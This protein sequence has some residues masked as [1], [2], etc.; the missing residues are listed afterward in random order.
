MKTIFHSLF[1]LIILAIITSA[2]GYNLST[3]HTILIQSTDKNISS[4]LLARSEEIISARLKDFSTGIFNISIV[5]EK[6]QI[7]ITFP[8][9]WDYQTI[10][11]LIVHKG[12]I[13]FYETC[14]HQNLVELLNGDKYL[15]TL[16]TKSETDNEGAKIGCTTDKGKVNDFLGTLELSRQAKFTWSEEYDDSTFCLYALKL[17][18]NKGPIIT[19][20][21][22][23]SAKF[24]QERIQI[25]L[26]TDAVKLWSDATK[27]NLGKAIALV[28]DDNVIS[29]PKV[30][31]VI[32]SGEIEITGKFTSDQTGYIAAL[33]NN[34]V[35][36]VNFIVV[37]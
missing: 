34:G 9:D 27:R 33:L 19:G 28:L 23:E 29:A 20:C 30:R 1:L 8:D 10:E 3:K 21:D 32:E 13:E 11:N 31:S 6:K 26:N 14:N 12:T 15:F 25:K 4:D 17:G 37:N 35:L 24:D 36:P 7:K 16:L 22:I 2:S 5:Q 18:N